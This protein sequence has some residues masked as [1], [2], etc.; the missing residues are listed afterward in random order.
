MFYFQDVK[1]DKRVNVK[2]IGS[3]TGTMNITSAAGIQINGNIKAA[4]S[5][6]NLTATG[7]DIVVTNATAELDFG[8][9]TLNASGSIGTLSN[10]ITMLQDS[11]N[12]I[13]ATAGS[14]VHL[15]TETGTLRFADDAQ[16]AIGIGLGEG[17]T[18]Q[19]IDVL[20]QQGLGV[21]QPD[22]II[23]IDALEDAG[24]PESAEADGDE[25]LIQQSSL[26][27]FLVPAS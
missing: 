1:A 26:E 14:G 27:G 17:T 13:D 8:N 15:R 3:D 21:A 10:P 20:L 22:A 6:V 25:V 24:A 18:T 16:G 12:T 11:A 7:G 19:P 9:L 2:F 23:D 4:G 5:N